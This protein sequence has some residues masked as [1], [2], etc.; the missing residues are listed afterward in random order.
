MHELHLHCYLVLELDYLHNNTSFWLYTFKPSYVRQS[1]SCP[2]LGKLVRPLFML[3]FNHT[4]PTKGLDA[5]RISREG[6]NHSRL[7]KLFSRICKLMQKISKICLT[8]TTNPSR[9]CIRSHE[10]F[11][12]VWLHAIELKT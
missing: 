4:K 9:Q 1:I 8:P 2:S 3:S 11:V 6:S 7:Y 10:I 5:L 12:R